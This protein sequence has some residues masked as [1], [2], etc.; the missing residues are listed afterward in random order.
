MLRDRRRGVGEQ[1]RSLGQFLGRVAEPQRR[2]QSGGV[3]AL[4]PYPWPPSGLASNFNG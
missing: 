1:P 2:R 4:E 3:L